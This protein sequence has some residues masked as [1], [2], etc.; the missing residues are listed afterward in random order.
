MSKAEAGVH[1]PLTKSEAERAVLR[2][3][4]RI[5]RAI[6][7]YDPMQFAVAIARRDRM[8]AT[9]IEYLAQSPPDVLVHALEANCAYYNTHYRTDLTHKAF[10]DVVNLWHEFVHPSLLFSIE[11]R[12]GILDFIADMHRTQ[13]GLQHST[14]VVPLGRAALIFA[15]ER[16]IP[17]ASAA[18]A[19]RFGLSPRSWLRAWFCFW[20]AVFSRDPM[21]DLHDRHLGWRLWVEPSYLEQANLPQLT[22]VDIAAFLADV[23]C[24]PEKIGR[25]YRERRGLPPSGR[26][27]NPLLWRQLP[28]T[29]VRNPILTIEQRHFVPISKLLWGLLRDGLMERFRSLDDAMFKEVSTSF[30]RY[31]RSMFE[32]ESGC[33]KAL[34]AEKLPRGAGKACDLA[35]VLHDAVLLI[36]CKAVLLGTDFATMN[37]IKGSSAASAIAEGIEQVRETGC[38]L[39]DTGFESIEFAKGKP[40]YGIVATYGYIPCANADL[41]DQSNG[42]QGTN[43]PRERCRTEG[44]LAAKP[45]VLDIDAVE[46]LVLALREAKGRLAPTWTEFESSNRAI[47]GDWREFLGR[48]VRA[49]QSRDLDYWRTRY[50]HAVFAS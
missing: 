32:S 21:M 26:L 42:A 30:V 2:F 16:E 36:E 28:P 43:D 38:R 47:S 29:I 17:K 25:E 20:A 4:D 40:L 39:H 12:N 33:V 37:A 50:E 18:F 7:R 3:E 1:P 31:V 23:A 8:G 45:Y 48:R 14:W 49:M 41:F 22:R 24:T 44:R 9:S 15:D 10:A 34:N 11:Q 5:R 27:T 13:L 35:I 46:L 6:R 19:R